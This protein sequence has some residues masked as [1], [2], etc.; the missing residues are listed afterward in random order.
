VETPR[1]KVM[2]KNARIEAWG[3]E[4]RTNN[5]GFRDNK[6]KIPPKKTSE[7]RIIVLGDSFTVSAGVDFDHIYTSLLKKQIG[8]SFPRV[9]VINLGVGGYNLLQYK[10]VLTEVGLSLN[11]DMIIV[12]LFPENDFN[13]DTYQN[14]YLIAAGERQSYEPPWYDRLYVYRA[15]LYKLHNFAKNFIKRFHDKQGKPA[16]DLSGWRKNVDAL[17]DISDIARRHHLPLVAAMLPINWHFEKQ[18]GLFDR[19]R[20]VCENNAIDAVDLLESFIAL[21]ID[22]SSLRLNP[23]DAHPNEQYNA[24]VAEYLSPH[25]IQ[26]M[27]AEM[28]KKRR[29]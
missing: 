11:P 28:R 21:Q 16:Q 26:I 15:Y 5:L 29:Q 23:I 19:C 4:L 2:R 25:I 3:V 20:R 9:E 7:F 17:L 22:P 27:N 18:R 10:H 12:A 24:I 1:C 14:N 6:S 8:R 13:M